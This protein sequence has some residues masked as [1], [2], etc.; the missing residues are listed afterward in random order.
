ME[1]LIKIISHNVDA[2]EGDYILKAVFLNSDVIELHFDN[3]KSKEEF[4]KHL[5]C[6]GEGILKQLKNHD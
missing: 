3:I 4:A 1:P 6:F 2:L 5:I